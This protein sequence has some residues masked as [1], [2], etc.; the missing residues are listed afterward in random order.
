MLDFKVKKAMSRRLI[1]VMWR[2]VLRYDKL[3]FCAG[4]L[5]G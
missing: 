2:E 1:I 3:D 4:D 5:V